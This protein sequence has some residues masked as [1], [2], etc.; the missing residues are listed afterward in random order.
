VREYLTETRKLPGKIIDRLYERNLIYADDTQNAV[1][2]RHAT[3][4]E[5]QTWQRGD[6]TGASLRGT[7]G[8]NNQFH[9]LVQDSSQEDGW[10]WVGIGQGTVQR[11]IVTESAID[12]LSLMVLDKPHRPTNGITIYLS[13]DGQGL[14]P[15]E[16]LKQ[17][18]AAGGQ[19]LVAF[20]AD[21][22]GEMTA[23]RV[24]QELPGVRRI[25]PAYG[26]DWNERLVWDGQPQQAPQVERDKQ[27]LNGLWKWHRV[28]HEIGRSSDYVRRITE[29]AREVV[30]GGKLSERARAA[31]VRD[32]EAF[33]RQQMRGKGRSKSIE[34]AD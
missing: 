2:L 15:M 16:A 17:V 28:A 10:F 33:E 12:A 5:N 6:L 14:M 8:E 31:M 1:F 13:T 34:M 23:W 24:A 20:D 29:V 19:V 9:S 22:S 4:S 26:E 7:S 27:A 32:L 3:Y 11:V 21:Q 30:Q 25:T 18:L